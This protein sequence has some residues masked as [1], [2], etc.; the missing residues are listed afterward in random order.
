MGLRCI[1]QD[2]SCT[3]ITEHKGK[4]NFSQREL[5]H[6]KNVIFYNAQKQ[7]IFGKNC[8][9][10]YESFYIQVLDTTLPISL[11]FC[12]KILHFLFFEGSNDR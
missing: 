8:E 9:A 12:V 2:M 6:F 5:F 11:R 7:C 10:K 1:F 4:H 3:E